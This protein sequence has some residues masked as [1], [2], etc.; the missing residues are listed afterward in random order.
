MALFRCGSGSDAVA[1]L[2]PMKLFLQKHGD[3]SATAKDIVSGTANSLSGSFRGGSCV[4][5]ITGFNGTMTIAGQGGS[6]GFVFGLKE[7]VFTS[8]GTS[9]VDVSN[10][11]YIVFSFAPSSDISSLSVTFTAT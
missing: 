5:N 7:G 9:G 1:F 4:A 10:Y 8:L 2:E 3:T 6:A 11:D